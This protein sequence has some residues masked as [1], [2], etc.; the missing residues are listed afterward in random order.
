[1][2]FYIAFDFRLECAKVNKRKRRKDRSTVLSFTL[3][4]HD[5]PICITQRKAFRLFSLLLTFSTDQW[6]SFLTPERTGFHFIVIQ[7]GAKLCVTA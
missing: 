4:E 5:F 6:K 3:P 7:R 1:M 2:K